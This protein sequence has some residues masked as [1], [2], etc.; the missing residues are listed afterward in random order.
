MLTFVAGAPMS[1]D[2]KII[3]LKRDFERLCDAFDQDTT[4]TESGNRFVIVGSLVC[5]CVRSLSTTPAK[6]V[7]LDLLLAL[8]TRVLDEYKYVAAKA[9][10]F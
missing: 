7:A 5:A 4:S 2:Q 9:C 10:Y 8:S 1:P 3:K 6:L